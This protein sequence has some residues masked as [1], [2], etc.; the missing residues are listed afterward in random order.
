M[1][2]LY[3]FYWKTCTWLVE[4]QSEADLPWRAKIL[5]PR[6][7]WFWLSL[8]QEKGSRQTDTRW[9]GEAPKTIAKLAY[10]LRVTYVT[11]DLMILWVYKPTYTDRMWCFHQLFCHFADFRCLLWITWTVVLWQ[12]QSLNAQTRT[13]HLQRNHTIMGFTC[14]KHN[15]FWP[16]IWYLKY[17]YVTV[18]YSGNV[19][20]FWTQL[21]IFPGWA[22]W[23]LDITDLSI[24]SCPSSSCTE[25][26]TILGG[27]RGIWASIGHRLGVWYH[28]IAI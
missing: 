21:P 4:P 8:T 15:M 26:R 12:P 10:N 7:A 27:K 20:R 11:Y 19:V 16:M 18:V 17:R 9:Q 22:R 1:S 14:L 3:I 23:F 28:W 5:T 25:K 13:L 2:P 24:P 6:F